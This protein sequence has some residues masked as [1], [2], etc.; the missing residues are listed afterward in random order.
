AVWKSKPLASKLRNKRACWP[1]ARPSTVPKTKRASVPKKKQSFD[2]KLKPCA[3]P[4]KRLR[5][6]EPKP[7]LLANWLK[8]KR[9][10]APKRR[11]SAEQKKNCAHVRSKRPAA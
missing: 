8:R 1:N 7:K 11:P 4:R 3:K 5:A 2:R 10:A 6:S 9:G